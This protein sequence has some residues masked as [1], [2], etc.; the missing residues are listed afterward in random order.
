MGQKSL[1]LM[2]RGGLAAIVYL[3]AVFAFRAG[4]EV[5]ARQGVPDMGLFAQ[6]YYA[7]GLFI[8]GGMDL[9]T[10]SGGPHVARVLLWTTY[11]AAPLITTSTV[12][13]GLRFI[14]YGAMERFGM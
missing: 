2:V 1:G 10:P 6:L 7:G 8:L 11:F 3:L 4:V 12:L 13:E 14:G 5:S 9:G